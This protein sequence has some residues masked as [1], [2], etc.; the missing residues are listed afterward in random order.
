MQSWCR[1]SRSCYRFG[2][3]TQTGR[4]GAIG[5]V[6]LISAMLFLVN[7]VEALVP[8]FVPV[9]VR[10][11][12]IVVAALMVGVVLDVVRWAWADEHS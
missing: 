7:V 11:E 3:A 10:V 8:P 9:W 12:M 6:A 4:H 2:Y 1:C 5:A